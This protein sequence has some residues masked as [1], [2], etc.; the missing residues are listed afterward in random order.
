MRL[1]EASLGRLLLWHH[2]VMATEEDKQAARERL[3]KL[4]GRYEKAENQL[5]EV[6]KEV[7]DEIAATLMARILGP[8]EVT[9]LSPFERQHVGR[10]AKAAG[11][12]PLR[13]ATVVSRAK[14]AAKDQSPAVP[15]PVEQP[16]PAVKQRRRA[17]TVI[18]EGRPLTDEE[19]KT[20]AELAHSRASD[21]QAQKLKQNAAQVG[22]G[23]KDF[24]VV[25][26]AMSMGL[27]K[28]DEVYAELEERPAGSE[29]NTP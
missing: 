23:Y 5:E 3:A 28:H 24:T 21:L 4:T 18:K 8:S 17:E 1:D 10:I 14:A 26:S 6:R 11:V 27:L 13:E 7:T 15:A 9:R 12:P 16:R 20:L 19:A 22:D 29:E 2:R 25:A